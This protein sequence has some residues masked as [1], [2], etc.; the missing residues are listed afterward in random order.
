MAGR[1][2]VS[3]DVRI[4]AHGIGATVD[5]WALWDAAAKRAGMSRQQWIRT[6]LTA[7]AR[8]PQKGG[9]A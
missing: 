7:A 6:T 2:R 4:V 8:E 9:E 1:P 5:T 3:D